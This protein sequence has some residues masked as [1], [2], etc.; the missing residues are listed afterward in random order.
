[1]IEKTSYETVAEDGRR[2][3]YRRTYYSDFNLSEQERYKYQRDA[4]TTV[5]RV[6]KLLQSILVYIQFKDENKYHAYMDREDT[7]RDQ[8]ER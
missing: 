8:N 6:D 7:F 3:N 4:N 1:M 2:I 5:S